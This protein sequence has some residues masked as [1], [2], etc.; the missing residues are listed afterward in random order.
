MTGS[1]E[2]PSFRDGL[3]ATIIVLLTVFAVWKVID[4]RTQP[5]PPPNPIGM[6]ATQ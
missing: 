2:R 5:P 1:D 6:P 4:Y 3:I